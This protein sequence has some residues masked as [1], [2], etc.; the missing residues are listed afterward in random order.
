MSP[1]VDLNQR[2]RLRGELSLRQLLFAEEMTALLAL[3]RDP[4]R[5][6]GALV[7][8]RYRLGR[9]I[10]LRRAAIEEILGLPANGEVGRSIRAESR[11]TRDRM[12][13]AHLAQL[14]L[15]PATRM[16]AEPLALAA[17]LAPRLADVIAL[18]AAEAEAAARYLDHVVT[19]DLMPVWLEAAA[20]AAPA[21][22]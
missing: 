17:E 11:E 13:A 12:H 22:P 2:L 18:A 21:H 8:A 10:R 5:R 14:G 9:A 3:A 15:W 16:E 6:P 7:E 19:P 20:R 1:T 4:A